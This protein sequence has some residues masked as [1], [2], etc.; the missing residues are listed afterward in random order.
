MGLIGEFYIRMMMMVTSS[1]MINLSHNHNHGLVGGMLEVDERER[2][3][4]R[5]IK[6]H[7]L[8]EHLLEEI[9]RDILINYH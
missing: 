9:W 7:P 2:E 5:C 1:K 3:G 8:E 6:T 4:S